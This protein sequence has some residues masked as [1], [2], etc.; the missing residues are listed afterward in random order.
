M[1]PFVITSR[2]SIPVGDLGNLKPAVNLLPFVIQTI[3][4]YLL[5]EN[6]AVAGRRI[7]FSVVGLAKLL[8]SIRFKI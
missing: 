6:S 4:Y 7:K 5:F 8:A 2:P 3:F 1:P